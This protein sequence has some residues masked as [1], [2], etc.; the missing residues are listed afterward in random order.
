MTCVPRKRYAWTTS[1]A[2]PSS[3]STP[4]GAKVGSGPA[5]VP[6]KISGTQRAY[7]IRIEVYCS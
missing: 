5:T 1:P 3:R 4:D 2:A 7:T 6:V